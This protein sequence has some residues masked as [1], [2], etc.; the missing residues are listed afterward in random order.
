VCISVPA[1]IGSYGVEDV[2]VL[3]LSSEEQ[4]AFEKSAKLL[5]DN[6]ASVDLVK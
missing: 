6:I 2:I 1:R 3:D 4:A 5:K